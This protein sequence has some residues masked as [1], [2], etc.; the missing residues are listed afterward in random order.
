MKLAAENKVGKYLRYA[1][2]EILLV[3]IGILIALQINNWNQERI[4]RNEEQNILNNL[5]AEFLLNSNILKDNITTNEKCYN[6]GIFIMH[7]IGKDRESISTNNTDSLIYYSIEYSKFSPSENV[8]AD[9]LQS[10]RLQL[11]SNDKLRETL[12]KWSQ[13]IKHAEDDYKGVDDK[14]RL[15]LL[16]YLSKNYPLKDVDAYG[17]LNWQ[18]KSR[19]EIDKLQIFYDM[20]Y[21]NIM[22][23]LLYKL[24]WYN[25][26]T[27]R[28]EKIIDTILEETKT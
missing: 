1:I 10:G 28:L 20:E 3:V 26:V 19:L 9:L 11:I 25:D 24:N 13:E 4:A 18:E 23:D 16:P 12:Y 6:T 14:I 22:D 17:P 15:S 5:H 2:G 27:H 8:L 7:L 21:E